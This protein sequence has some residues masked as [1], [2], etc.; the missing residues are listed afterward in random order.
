[1][2]K[3][4]EALE[5]ISKIVYL[6]H[7]KFDLTSAIIYYV[8]AKVLDIEMRDRNICFVSLI[9][10]VEVFANEEENEFPAH[11]EMLSEL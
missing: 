10:Q 3:N 1:M 6:M 8:M 7:P 5:K 11:M 9:K 2:I 4:M